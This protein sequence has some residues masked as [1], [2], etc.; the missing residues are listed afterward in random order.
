MKKYWL[1]LEPY[2]FIFEGLKKCLIYNT[3]NG[4]C[5][6]VLNN[7]KL[8]SIVCGL[9]EKKSGYCISLTDSD[10]QNEDV[11]NFI[12]DLRRIFAGDLIELSDLNVKPFIF[13]PVLRFS[14]NNSRTNSLDDTDFSKNVLLNI[15]SVVLY[16]DATC[17]QSCKYCNSYFKQF[18]FCTKK[19]ILNELSL[20]DYKLLFDKLLVANIHRLNLVFN[21]FKSFLFSDLFLLLERYDFEIFVYVNYLNLK[22]FLESDYFINVKICVLVNSPVDELLLDDCVLHNNK[23]S[24]LFNVSNYTEFTTVNELIDK[25]SINAEINPFYNGENISFFKENVFLSLE[26]VLSDT[27]CKRQIYARSVLNEN[28]FGNIFIFS[29]G[30]VYTNLNHSPLGN[31]KEQSLNELIFREL[32]NENSVWLMKRDKAPCSTCIYNLLCPSLGNYELV[33]GKNNLCNIE[34]D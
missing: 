30:S 26:D 27:V 23:L 3:I 8:Y 16:I 22:P 34:Q 4:K 10:L 19:K 2:V 5:V 28:F 24:W 31:L 33:L 25:Y 32:S 12:T 11:A 6:N 20:I 17:S 21:D 9:N 29:D 1:Y 15:R 18:L 13:K 14:D 7:S